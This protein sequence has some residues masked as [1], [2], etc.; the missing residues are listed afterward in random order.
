[1]VWLCGLVG[2]GA[3][4]TAKGLL[5]GFLPPS[6]IVVVVSRPPTQPHPYTQTHIYLQVVVH[7]VHGR[8][9]GGLMQ[10]PVQPVEAGIL[11]QLV[12]VD[13]VV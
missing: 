10:E 8:V 9:E 7:L 12:C 11:D 6:L 3:Y 13:V 2:A 5:A 1:M 4:S